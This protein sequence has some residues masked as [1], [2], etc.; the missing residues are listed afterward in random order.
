MKIV[1]QKITLTI[2][3]NYDKSKIFNSPNI[4]HNIIKMPLKVLYT[5]IHGL[6]PHQLFHP[7]IHTTFR[8]A[9]EKHETS[10]GLCGTCSKSR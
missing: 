7:S 5:Y 8:H 9:Y 4:K 1:K 3:C 6:L 2:Y 10:K